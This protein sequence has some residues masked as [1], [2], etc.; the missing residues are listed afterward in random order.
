MSVGHL[1][2]TIIGQA[3]YNIFKFKGYKVIGDNHLGD[4]GK[5]FGVLIAAYKEAR[6]IRN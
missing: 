6:K 3:L 1:R 4:W 2:S 5:Q